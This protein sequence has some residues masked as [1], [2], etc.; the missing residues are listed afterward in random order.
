MG[1]GG[2]GEWR[3]RERERERER[4]RFNNAAGIPIELL[5]PLHVYQLER[6]IL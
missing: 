6:E 3:Q 4:G 2:E 5:V 1:I